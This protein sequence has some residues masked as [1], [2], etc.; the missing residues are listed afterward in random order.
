MN[1]NDVNLLSGEAFPEDL[2]ET[3]RLRPQTFDQY[4]GQTEVIE[5]LKVAIQATLMRGEPLDHVLLHGPPGLGKT[6]LASLIARA[7]AV[8]FLSSSGPALEKG[9]DLVGILTRI[10][11]GT[12][13]FIDEI[14]RLPR[15]VEEILYSAMED[16]AIDVIFDRGASAR[17]FRHRI[18]PFTLIGATTRAGLLSPP[19]RDRFG[20]QRDLEFYAPEDLASILLRS[21]GLLEIEIE[22]SAALEIG[23][24]S[25]G[26]PRIANRLLKRVRDFLQ[27]HA[28]GP[29]TVE[30]ARNALKLEG[31]DDRGLNRI[32]R[33]FIET[34]RT[35]YNGGPVGIEAMAA[36]LQMDPDTLID[37]VEPFLLKEGYLARTPSGRKLTSAGWDL[38][39]DF[40]ANPGKNVRTPVR[41][42]ES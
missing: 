21:A 6:T 25:R 34:L 37:V 32:D 5:S 7:L 42:Q 8:P 10:A 17:T 33:K 29:V 19:L 22:D 27:V 40:L 16:F 24:R 23:R 38:E 9:G 15:P 2:P 1:P 20:I 18:A 3:N 36:T 13:L 39:V 28:R 14:H 41:S 26:T 11:P 35:V 4:V 12:L 30:I 31:I